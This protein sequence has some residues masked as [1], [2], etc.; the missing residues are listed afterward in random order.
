MWSVT[1]VT[2]V[3]PDSKLAASAVMVQLDVTARRSLG[4]AII[5]SCGLKTDGSGWEK[6]KESCKAEGASAGPRVA[7]F[8]FTCPWLLISLGGTN[9]IFFCASK[10]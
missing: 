1:W 6:K 3:A 4:D 2:P 5:V 8:I 10:S 9:C 7:R